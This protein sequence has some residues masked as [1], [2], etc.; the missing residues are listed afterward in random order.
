MNRNFATGRRCGWGEA[1]ISSNRA[2][3]G[4]LNQK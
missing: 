1:L 2:F 3:A 4:M